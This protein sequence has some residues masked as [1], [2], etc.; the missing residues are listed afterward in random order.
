M[1]GKMQ[2]KFSLLFLIFVLDMSAVEECMYGF[3]CDVE[4]FLLILS[5]IKISFCSKAKTLLFQRSCKIVQ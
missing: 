2:Y 1:D 4:C 3:V 5:A